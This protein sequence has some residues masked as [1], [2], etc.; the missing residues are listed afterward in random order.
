MDSG[1]YF[2]TKD[3]KFEVEKKEK[4]K[5]KELRKSLNKKEEKVDIF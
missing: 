2:L 1:K 5:E 4:V 3:Q